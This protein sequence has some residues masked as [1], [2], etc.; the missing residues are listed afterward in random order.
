MVKK[1]PSIILFLFFTLASHSD[2]MLYAVSYE[3]HF[4]I[5]IVAVQEPYID[6][7]VI[8]NP[9][10]HLPTRFVETIYR[11]FPY[12]GEHA[13]YLGHNDPRSF[14]TYFPFPE[15]DLMEISR[16]IQENDILFWT[17]DF[18]DGKIGYGKGPGVVDIIIEEGSGKTLHRIFRVSRLLQSGHQ[19]HLHVED[20]DPKLNAIREF[21]EMIAYRIYEFAALR[22]WDGGLPLG[23]NRATKLGRKESREHLIRLYK[24]YPYPPLQETIRQAFEYMGYKDKKVEKLLKE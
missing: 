6:E 23:H 17:E 10:K 1:F 8:Q 5:R 9:P 11:G 14:Q 18:G 12:T 2:E 22:H 15:L 4:E 19:I 13:R 3:T 24:K 20:D 21:S 7:Y 16:S